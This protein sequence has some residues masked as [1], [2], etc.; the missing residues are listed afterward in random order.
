MDWKIHTISSFLVYFVIILLFAFSFE[1]AVVSFLVLLFFSLFP[2]IDHPRSFIRKSVSMLIFY[3]AVLLIF[4]YLGVGIF[5]KVILSGITATLTYYLYR[6]LPLHHRGP[7]SLHRW[8]YA[9]IL[10]AALS[11]VF[12]FTNIEITLA[13]FVLFGYGLHLSLDKVREI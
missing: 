7:K 1:F 3:F 11:L 5:E 2:D 12:L 13:L 10:S 9:L 6:K 8:R 4:L